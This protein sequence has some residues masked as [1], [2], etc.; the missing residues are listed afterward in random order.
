[1]FSNYFRICIIYSERCSC[2]FGKLW[3]IY[4]LFTYASYIFHS[5]CVIVTSLQIS[6][7]CFVAQPIDF[8]IP[9]STVIFFGQS[10]V[11]RL[12]GPPRKFSFI[13]FINF[14]HNIYNLQECGVLGKGTESRMLLIFKMN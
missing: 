8:Y 3:Q 10:G 5:K 14:L 13:E 6:V 2:F 7:L 11:Y 1:M 4:N 12:K 9:W